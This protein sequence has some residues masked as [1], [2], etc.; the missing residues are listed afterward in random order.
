[1]PRPRRQVSPVLPSGMRACSW[2]RAGVSCTSLVSAVGMNPAATV[3]TRM[4]CGPHSTASVLMSPRSPLLAAAYA[5]R[6]RDAGPGARQGADEDDAAG[7]ALVDQ[8]AGHRRG[9]ARTR[10]EGA[11]RGAHPS[12]ACPDRP[13]GGARGGP[14]RGRGCRL[15]RALR[16]PRQAGD[17]PRRAHAGRRRWPT[18]CVQ[19]SPHRRRNAR[20]PPRF[21]PRSTTLRSR[22][23][24]V[25]ARRPRPGR[26]CR[27]SRVRVAR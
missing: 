3:L 14:P 23:R 19:R 20:A 8:L 5:D 18:P 26:G 4:P 1:M 17:R 12:P 21:A 10:C 11:P 6:L 27:R 16:W 9:Q 15:R 25:S 22:R 7:L 2:R 13:P 24:P